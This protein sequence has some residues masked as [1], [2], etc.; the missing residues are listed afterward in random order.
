[1]LGCQL[2]QRCHVLSR[3]FLLGDNFS[4]LDDPPYVRSRDPLLPKTRAPLPYLH[5]ISNEAIG[6]DDLQGPESQLPPEGP[7]IFMV[8]FE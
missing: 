7:Q 1:M 4:L 8:E 3:P 2:P 6:I 5:L